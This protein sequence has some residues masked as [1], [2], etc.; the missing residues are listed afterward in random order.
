MM[1]RMALN[2]TRLVLS[3]AARWSGRKISQSMADWQ[4]AKQKR[5]AL[6]T[7]TIDYIK[8]IK[9]VRGSQGFLNL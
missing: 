4:E 9:M 5:I 6:T 7:S 3:Q 1:T 8:Q 2:M